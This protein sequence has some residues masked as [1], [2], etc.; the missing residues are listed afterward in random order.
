VPVLAG[1]AKMPKQ[2]ELP[3]DLATLPQLSAV[4]FRV[5]DDLQA[6]VRAIGKAVPVRR[7]QEGE[8]TPQ[9]RWVLNLL[10]REVQRINARSVELIDAK[11]TSRAFDELR[12]GMEVLM[13]LT[14]RSPEVSLTLHLGYLYSTSAKSR[15][16]K[17]GGEIEILRCVFLI[18]G[19]QENDTYREPWPAY[20]SLGRTVT[21]EPL[22]R[23]SIGS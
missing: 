17:A 2:E 1:G 10:E 20:T 23:K 18:H 13:C 12:E 8:S 21:S 22:G 14:E 5:H 4:T 11:R 6:L 19:R 7:A 9:Q 3:A 15:A 16:A